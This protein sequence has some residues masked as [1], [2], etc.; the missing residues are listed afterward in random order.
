MRGMMSVGND[1]KNHAMA[2]FSGDA[3]EEKRRNLVN[4]DI[5]EQN[6]ASKAQQTNSA[7]DAA[8]IAVGM[9]LS[10]II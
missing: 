2:G 9:L 8:T 3:K 4:L 6:T 5:E 1:Y 10:K 7:V